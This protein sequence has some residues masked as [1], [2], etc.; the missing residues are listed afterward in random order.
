MAALCGP[1]DAAGL[2]D[3][4]EV[5]EIAEVKLH[6]KELRGVGPSGARRAAG[7]AIEADCLHR[8]PGPRID[9]YNGEP[10]RFPLGDATREV[11]GRLTEGH[12]LASGCQRAASRGT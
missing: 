2:R 12:A 5:L 9:A 4:D 1:R 10:F 7:D 3:R 6:G 11:C 8:P